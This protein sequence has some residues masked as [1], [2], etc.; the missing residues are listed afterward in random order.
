MNIYFCRYIHR[1]SIWICEHI[2]TIP[3]KTRCDFRGAWSR[4]GLGVAVRRR[5]P[6]AGGH[7]EETHE[8]WECEWYSEGLPSAALYGWL[9]CFILSFFSLPCEEF[10]F[11]FASRRHSNLLEERRREFASSG[12]GSEQLTCWPSSLPSFAE[13]CPCR[14]V[15][16]PGGVGRA[17]RPGLSGSPKAPKK[18]KPGGRSGCPRRHKRCCFPVLSRK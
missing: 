15:T 18:A 10:Y 6:G 11:S 9:T 14:Q 7:A 16:G 1:L 4:R 2:G 12:P 13:L 8:V 5:A 17:Q 3:G